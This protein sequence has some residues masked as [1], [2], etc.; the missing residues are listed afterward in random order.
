MIV[1]LSKNGVAVLTPR[2]WNL[3]KNYLNADYKIRGEFLLQTQVRLREAMYLADHPECFRKENAAIF[4]PKVKDMG[5]LKC[6]FKE[7]TILLSPAGVEAVEELYKNNIKFPSYQAM[8]G[9]FKRAARDADFDTR[10]IMTKMLRK[11]FISWLMACYTMEQAK[12]AMSAGHTI[13]IMQ[14][15]YIT[16]GF[17]KTDL[18]DIKNATYNWGVAI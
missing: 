7:R 6:R 4:L 3:I 11:S 14:A 16:F 10:Y 17:K 15:Y 2:D 13:E 1:P 9:A 18:D 5:K 8:D 12:I